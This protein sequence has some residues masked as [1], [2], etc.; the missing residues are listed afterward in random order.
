MIKMGN[1]LS[2]LNVILLIVQIFG[3][4]WIG[5]VANNLQSQ[6]SDIQKALYDFAPQV[7][8]F[9]NGYIWVYEYKDNTTANIEILINAPHS[10]NIT[11]L[12]NRFYPLSE[13]FDPKKLGFDQFGLKDPIRDTTYPQAYRF[14]AEVNLIANLYPSQNLTNIDFFPAGQLEFEILYFDVP[15]NTLYT[16]F[17]NGS[18]YFQFVK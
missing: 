9:C 8:G 5:I 12:V 15:K 14:R 11:L 16:T 7:S 18:V 2:F 10:G 3:V 13:Y 6:N 17:F 1:R 4:F